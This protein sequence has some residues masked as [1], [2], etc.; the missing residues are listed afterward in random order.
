V[1]GKLLRKAPSGVKDSWENLKDFAFSEKNEEWGELRSAL[2][3][4]RSNNNFHYYK[5]NTLLSGY[6]NHFFESDH[7]PEEIRKYALMN[8]GHT[9]MQMG[10]YFADAATQGY[11]IKKIPMYEEIQRNI[12]RALNE[13]IVTGLSW[14]IEKFFNVYGRDHNRGIG[15][16]E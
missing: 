15:F 10:Y 9:P 16:N 12:A 3:Q 2:A 14:F 1:F 7:V 4:V 13:S 11:L 5:L 8:K 6:N